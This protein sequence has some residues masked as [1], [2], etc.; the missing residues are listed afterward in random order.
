MG[1]HGKE[2]LQRDGE[3]FESGRHVILTVMMHWCILY[4]DLSNYILCNLLYVNYAS[5]KWFYMRR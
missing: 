2:G 3:H 4:A 1:R 5:V